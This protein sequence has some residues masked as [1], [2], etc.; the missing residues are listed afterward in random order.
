MNQRNEEQK[1]LK[2]LRQA[3][4]I[5]QEK[6]GR[7]LGVSFRTVSDWETRKGMPRFDNAVALAKELGV[8]LKTLAEAM[9]IDISDLP[10]DIP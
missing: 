9:G 1:T 8:S 6:L 7:R 2:H 3:L 10:D 5:S 4:S